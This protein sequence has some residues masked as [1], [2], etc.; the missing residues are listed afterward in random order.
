MEELKTEWDFGPLLKKD[1]SG[2][3]ETIRKAYLKFRDKWKNNPKYIEEPEIL[4]EA[5]DE[6]E[7]LQ[8]FY[9]YGGDEYYFYWLK[10]QINQTDP[11]LKAGLNKV[12]EFAKDN[13][14]EISFFAINLSKISEDKQMKLLNSDILNKYK[15][16]LERLFAEGRY[17]LT[18]KEEQIMNLKSS[19]SYSFWADMLS[20]FLSR[21]EDVVLDEN[22]K[23]T[24]KNYSE[25][26]SLTH[27]QNKDIR[28][29]AIKSF[30]KIIE[31]YEDVA[32]NEI[33]A[34]LEHKKTNDKIRNYERPDKSR[35]IEDDIESEVVDS[36]T[37]SVSSRGFKIAHDYYKF[38]AKLLKMNK[39]TYSER[40]IEYG[41]VSGN[42]DFENSSELV[43]NVF[44]KL[45]EKF[46]EILE[47]FIKEGN[48]D[49]FPKKGKRSGAFCVIQLKE[50]PVYVM[51]NHTNKLKDVSTFAHEMGHAVNDEFMKKNLNS[52]NI[53]SP[54]S[55]AEVA[56]TFMEDFVLQ[57]LLKG[58]DDEVKLVIMV[59]KLQNDIQTIMRQIACYNFE[60]EL[61]KEFRE[62]GY[63]S[64]ED[65]GKI[66][67]EN[68]SAYL[69]ESFEKGKDMENGWIHW[70]HIRYY[71][72]VYSYASGLLISKSMQKMVKENPENIEKVKEF[73]SAGTSDSPKNIFMKMGIDISDNKFWDKG[74][75]EIESLLDETEDLA[76]KL[77]KI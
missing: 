39:F 23:E 64:K 16:F 25:I 2:E 24:K 72:Y 19:S 68:I 6:Y 54:K 63:L 37:E 49:A 34:I 7:N 50:Q 26:D 38:K 70:P 56:S 4:R 53:G 46:Y 62:K 11:E 31:K 41:E 60:K 13:S 18:E 75:D 73:L 15:H 10:S 61:H 51:L 22:L 9:H 66:F 17:T 77:G 27:N 3:R 43:K 32:E 12:E 28:E 30:N 36:L 74:L 52:L 57:E 47:K 45:D 1:F 35:H 33:N 14:N 5:L 58:A 42:F 55:T 29:R 40:N 76:K 44:M 21:E 48:I 67:S 69:G 71:F 59:Q 8:R 65:I 20:G